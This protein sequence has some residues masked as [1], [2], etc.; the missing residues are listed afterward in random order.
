MAYDEVLARRIR[1]VLAESPD[2]VEKKMFGGIAFLVRGNMCCGVIG[3]Q[4]M[5][6]VGPKEYETALAQPHVRKM[7]F[8][9]RTPKGFIYVDPAGFASDRDLK[10]W[11]A[12][13]KKFALSLPAK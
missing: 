5:I 9:G 11:T 1:K 2:V 12:K 7:D 4:L 3:N 8:S 10:A 6:R 13:G